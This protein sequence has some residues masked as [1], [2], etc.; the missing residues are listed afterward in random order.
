MKLSEVER[1]ALQWWRNKAPVGYDDAAHYV[2]FAINC[3]TNAEIDLARKVS[4][5]SERMRLEKFL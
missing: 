1:A 2:N 5:L 4:R 3:T